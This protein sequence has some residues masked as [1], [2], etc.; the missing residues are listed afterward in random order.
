MSWSVPK[1]SL[2][3]ASFLLVTSRFAVPVLE[4]AEIE[5]C[6]LN[7]KVDSLKAGVKSPT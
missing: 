1:T 3:Q 7:S 6:L 2:K 4:E 5:M